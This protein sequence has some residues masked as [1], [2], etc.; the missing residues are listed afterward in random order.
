MKSPIFQPCL[1]FRQTAASA[2]KNAIKLDGYQGI[3][4]NNAE[5]LC[6]TRSHEV[7][8]TVLSW[9]WLLQEM[10]QDWLAAP[11]SCQIRLSAY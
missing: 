1:I 2:I 11:H 10:S 7:D 5:R 6:R 8:W 3:G 9:N 4:E